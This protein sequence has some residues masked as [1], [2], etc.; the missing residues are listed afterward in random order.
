MITKTFGGVFGLQFLSR[1]GA[2]ARPMPG[3]IRLSRVI[4][5]TNADK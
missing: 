4:Q 3:K 5:Q 1:A 2:T